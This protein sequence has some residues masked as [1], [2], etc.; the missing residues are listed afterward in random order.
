MLDGW[1]LHRAFSQSELVQ[2]AGVSRAQ[3]D[4]LF[5]AKLGQTP[6]QYFDRRRLRHA[7]RSLQLPDRPIKEVAFDLGFRHVSSFSAWFKQKT[8]VN[9]NARREK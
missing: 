4:R 3:L 7:E 6:H 9:P 8:G 1:P 2:Q 5:T